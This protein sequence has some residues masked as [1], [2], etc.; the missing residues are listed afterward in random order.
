MKK[1]NN[2]GAA[3][4]SVMIAIVFISIVS[5]TLLVIT[6][7]NYQMKVVNSQSKSNFYETE[8]RINVVTAQVRNKIVGSSNV[9]ESVGSVL[10]SNTT[11]T[12]TG[13][14]YTFPYDKAKVATLAFPD[15]TS[16]ETGTDSEGYFVKVYKE[17]PHSSTT[18]Y[19]KFYFYDG[20]VE[21]QDK[22]NGKQITVQ[23]LKIK[24]VSSEESGGYENTIKTDV[25]FYVEISSSNG[26][27]GGGVGSCAFL[28]DTNIKTDPNDHATRLNISGNTI[29]GEYVLQSGTYLT[30]FKDNQACDPAVSTSYSAP[31]SITKSKTGDTVSSIT[32]NTGSNA[33]IYLKDSCFMNFNGDYNVIL[34]DIFIT[35]QSVLSVLDGTFTVYGDIFVCGNA[36]FICNGTLKMGYNSNI[37]KVSNN[38]N[39]CE[40][41]TASSPN[42]N[43]IITNNTIGH[44]DKQNYDKIADLLKLFDNNGNND[45]VLPNIVQEEPHIHKYFYNVSPGGDMQAKSNA[46]CTFNG[47][48]YY[49]EYPE[50]NLHFAD[51]NNGSLK[52]QNELILIHDNVNEGK[53]KITSSIP[54]S[55]I[56]S[57][58]PLY[59]YDTMNINVSCM[60]DQAFNY[61]I[62]VNNEHPTTPCKIT[63]TPNGGSQTTVNI[64]DFF[65]PNCNS[66][67]QSVFNISS[68]GGT[69]ST[70]TPTKTAIAYEK[71]IKE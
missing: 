31:K 37:Y 16:L 23:N 60:G 64:K 45:G 61:I 7:N 56:L 39:S 53:I 3:L 36:A 48:S 47:I 46:L 8:Q 15:I 67:V 66:F 4:I 54:N 63:F 14:H 27:G 69:T 22:T 58:K 10:N 2:K 20:N 28:V 33:V 12:Y 5:T 65:K 68:G 21:V 49:A 17:E 42:K 59:V 51:S 57:R 9:A 35:D 44:L 43:V 62:D 50:N 32:M 13:A 19:D 52:F 40:K 34:G 24:Q 70:P 41:I 18:P 71:W 55:T 29:M 25:N 11:Q 38:G 1:Y 30:S 26:G 6:M